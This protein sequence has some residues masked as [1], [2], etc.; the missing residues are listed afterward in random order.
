MIKTIE[1]NI[2][3]SIDYKREIQGCYQ[4]ESLHLIKVSKIEKLD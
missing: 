1:V 4:L 3:H 2:T